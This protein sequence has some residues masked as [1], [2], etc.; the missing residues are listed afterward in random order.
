MWQACLPVTF[1]GPNTHNMKCQ[2]QLE[3]QR[4]S[5]NETA[6]LVAAQK[7]VSSSCCHD[8]VAKLDCEAAGCRS[9]G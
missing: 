1:G 8:Q 7:G 9:L 3:Q 5:A 2:C 6:L 4:I